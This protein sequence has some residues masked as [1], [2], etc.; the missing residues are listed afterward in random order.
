MVQITNQNMYYDEEVTPFKPDL[1][2]GLD[3]QKVYLNVIAASQTMKDTR[4][5]NGEVL[6]RQSMLKS[7]SKVPIQTVAVPL[8]SV[9]R[10]DIPNL[11]IEM[12]SDY[13]FVADLTS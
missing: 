5:P 7:L 6:H 13:N 10:Y 1:I 2:V 12:K 3:G 9:V 8:N 4:R 11:K